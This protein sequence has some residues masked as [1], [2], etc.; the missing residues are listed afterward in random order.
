M[1]FA[2]NLK[3]RETLDRIHW[4]CKLCLFFL[5]FTLLSL[6]MLCFHPQR[7]YHPIKHTLQFRT[8]S[9]N[10]STHPPSFP[11]QPLSKGADWMMPRC[12][13]SALLK[14]IFLSA[15]VEPAPLLHFPLLPEAS[16]FLFPG[17]VCPVGLV[18]LGF[19]V[20]CTLE[21]SNYPSK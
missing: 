8:A 5:C 10:P 16:V 1:P 19:A 9:P 6:L 20:G 18:S 3:L 21:C 14:S 4:H 12:R 15:L 17:P 7:I 2:Q 11:A 13:Y